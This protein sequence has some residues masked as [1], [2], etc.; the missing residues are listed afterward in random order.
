MYVTPHRYSTPVDVWS[1]GCIFAEMVR[2]S[3]LFPGTNEADQLKLIFRALGTPTPAI[4]PGITSLPDYR[5]GEYSMYPAPD[6]L[7]GLVPDLDANGLDLLTK[8]LQYDP[9]KR[10][11]ARD[12]LSHPYFADLPPA[13]LAGGVDGGAMHPGGAASSAGAA[14]AM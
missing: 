6:S 11:S 3:P 4:F 12:A 1:I 14:G 10:I 9:S 5:P 8:M 2:G 13:L 7:A